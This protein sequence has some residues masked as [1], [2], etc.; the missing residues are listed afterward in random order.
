MRICFSL[1]NYDR[2]HGGAALAARGMAR[3]LAELGHNVSIVQPGLDSNYRDHDVEV[4]TRP[5]RRPYLYRQ[6]DRDTLGW[7]RQWR[8]VIG[9]YLDSYATDLLVTQN[10]LLY[11]SVDAAAERGIPAVVWAHAYRI[12]CSDQFLHHDPLTEC[13]ADCSRC[14]S[15]LFAH[16]TRQNRAAYRQGLERANLVIS[17]SDYMRRVIER[18][19]GLTAP[20]VYPTFDIDHWAQPGNPGRESI[21]FTK[22]LKRKGLPIF[23]DVAREMPDRNFV[24]AGKASL[25]ARQALEALPNVTVIDWSDQMKSVYAD[26]RL[27]LGPAIWPEPFGRVYVEAASAGVPSITSNRGGIPEAI[28]DAGVLIDDIYDTQAWTA[29]IRALDDTARYEA[30]SEAAR[31]HARVFA[32]EQVAVALAEALR[33]ATGLELDLQHTNGTHQQS[34]AAGGA[35]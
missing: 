28:G 2:A 5:L 22:P 10:R 17:N 4:H 32:R 33:D 16:A 9:D 3:Y 23:I 21:L 35:E 29:A 27:L 20:V 31:E 24:V 30:L 1:D 18:F 13:D 34:V 14:V 25:S 8:K 12:F 7:N 26:T 11:S 19:L 6:N 15:G